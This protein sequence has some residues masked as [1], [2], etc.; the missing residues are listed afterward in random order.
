MISKTTI[1]FYENCES[2][3]TRIDDSMLCVFAFELVLFLGPLLGKPLCDSWDP[4][5]KDNILFVFP[6]RGHPHDGTK[7]PVLC[8]S[9]V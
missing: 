5:H 6:L 8:V 7:S 3:E 9:Y 2:I 1:K 4:H